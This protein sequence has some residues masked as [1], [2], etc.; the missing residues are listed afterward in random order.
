M[1]LTVSTNNLLQ[2]FFPILSYLIYRGV[3]LYLGGNLVDKPRYPPV[4]TF[5]FK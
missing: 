4:L 1:G 2:I 3:P 5:G